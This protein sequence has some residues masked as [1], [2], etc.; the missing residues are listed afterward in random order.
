LPGRL[1]VVARALDHHAEM[2]RDEQVNFFL[3]RSTLLT[4]QEAPGDIFD[5]VRR[6][7]EKQGS[8]IREN[9]VSFSE[10]DRD[11]AAR[12]SSHSERSEESPFATEIL[13]CAQDDSSLKFSQ[14]RARSF[15]ENFLC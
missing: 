3:G 12:T 1:F 8:R 6:R 7:I 2:V 13:R 15:S 5:S 10:T 9:D 4:F 14:I 11:S